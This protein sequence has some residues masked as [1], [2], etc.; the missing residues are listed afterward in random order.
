MILIRG[1][2]FWKLFSAFILVAA[3]GV[4]RFVFLGSL[5]THNPYLTFYPA[6]AV[7]AILGGFLPGILA[8]IL[9]A[10]F[11]DYFWL[12][13]VATFGIFHAADWVAMSTFLTSSIVISITSEVMHRAAQ[14]A[15]TAETQAQLAAEREKAAISLRE[16][17]ERYRMLFK[18]MLN[19]L[20]YCKMIF[21]D[22][23][24]HD[25]IYL[26]VNPAF[27]NL[28]GL[29]D[30]VGR[31]VT[32][33]IPGFSETYPELLEIYGR[34]AFSGL[35]ERHEVFIKD[36][37]IW[38]DIS[39]Y[40]AS[41]GYFTAVFENITDRKE[42]ISKIEQS[43]E[44]WEKTF[45]SVPDLIAIIDSDYRIIRVNRAMAERLGKTPEQC[46]GLHCYQYVHKLPHPPDYCPHAGTIK[47]GMEHVSE[48]HFFDSEWLVST[49]PLFDEFG[50]IAGAVHVARDIT[51]R[52]RI[53][54]ELRNARDELETRVR[55]RTVDLVSANEKL[56]EQAALIDLS[57]DAIL[58]RDMEDRISFWSK[59]SEATYGYKA[60]EALGK[61]TNE[62]LGT[63]SSDAI[64]DI[65]KSVLSQGRWSGE[66]V[67][68]TSGGD[69]IVVE[70]R[71]SLKPGKDERN[72]GFLE[73]ARNVTA[74]K[75][76][77]EMLRRTD[78]AFKALSQCNEAL[79]R[80]TEEME[81]LKRICQ[82]VVEVGGYRM[83]WVGRAEKDEAKSVRPLCFSGHEDGYLSLARITWADEKRGRGPVGASIRTGEFQVSKDL[84]ANPHFN[85]WRKS[86]L[87][88]GYASCLS[89]PLVVA[90]QVFGA[91]TIYAPEPDAFDEE[92]VRFLNSLA[93]NVSHGLS[94]IRTAIR[95]SE[96]EEAMRSYMERLERS[97]TDLEEFAFIASHDLQ[98]PMRKIQTFGSL[99]RK[100]YSGILDVTVMDYLTKIENSANRM[101]SLID[102]LLKY[103]RVTRSTEPFTEIDLT[104]LVAGAVE[105][106]DIKL[107]ESGGTI[108]VADLP[109]I[110]ADASQMY[111]LFQHL[112][113]NALK[114]RSGDRPPTIQIYGKEDA[115]ACRIYVEDN[116]I[117]FDEK[118]LP[119]IFK[120]FQQLH[121]REYEGTGMGLSICRKIV[122]QHGGTITARSKPGRGT[123][124]IFTLPLKRRGLEQAA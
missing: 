76:T 115:E 96:A 117:G 16:S 6:V 70:S 122:E 105:E 63:R 80:E 104:N 90:G 52:K 56:R 8:T 36:P 33:V 55:E 109:V 106:F 14:R 1:C 11:A 18:N 114:F 28:T 35:P 93:E 83:A 88:R 53:E 81:L 13:P 29:K 23:Q 30:V 3:A 65:K 91:L 4:F 40:S 44:E 84:M 10:L 79:V 86:A 46:I 121:G 20:A 59:G 57:P 50:D 102:A 77:E 58:V 99:L 7:A 74:K 26:A 69:E 2:A 43:K 47:D 39:V 61:R 87:E 54:N 49:S 42:M 123:T 100:G 34:V 113:G 101:R 15:K 112:I 67:H 118:Y 85:P 71:W 95:R 120:P 73:I 72:V 68:T 17:M 78:R 19:G 111:Q 32:E 110:Q 97:N 92:E 82:T 116:G 41:K 108:Q 64:E 22:G 62:L 25:F 89:L 98:E 37:D 45:N 66:L 12:E 27:E 75:R 94:S 60:E 38:L 103:S 51:D 48:V 31:K 5:G 107:K 119:L 21:D 124:F 9:S 24:P